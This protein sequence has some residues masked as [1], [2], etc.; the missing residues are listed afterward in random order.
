MVAGL[1][2]S[3]GLRWR[4][5]VG[6]RLGLA[7]VVQAGDGAACVAVSM[8]TVLYLDVSFLSLCLSFSFIFSLS[9]VTLSLGTL[10]SK[11]SETA[12]GGGWPEGGPGASGGQRG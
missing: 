7:M 2:P 4:G 9:A 11:D 3:W 1:C 12:Q 8:S 5:A 10:F 6:A